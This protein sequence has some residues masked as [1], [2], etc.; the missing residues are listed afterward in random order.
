[1]N[2][3]R[4]RL[5]AAMVLALAGGPP[6]ARAAPPLV[7]VWKSPACGCC[8][9]W[10]KHLQ[11]NGFEVKTHDI[12]NTEARAR[13][14][15]P[16]KYGACHTAQVAGYALEGHVPA[17]E[18]LRLIEEKPAAVGLAVPGMPRGSPGMDGPTYRGRRDP[19]DVLL[20]LRDG[21]ASVYQ[22]YR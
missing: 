14:G 3:L 21:S 7:E 4:R 22:A 16:V 15:L 17:R 12:G 2:W 1:M 19:F 11:V 9:D 8:K 6:L 13:L 5:N 10:V 20:V 18:V